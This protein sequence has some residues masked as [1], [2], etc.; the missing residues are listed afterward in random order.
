MTA[1]NTNKGYHII[2]RTD[3][4]NSEVEIEVSISVEL[5]QSHRGH[6]L[7]HINDRLEIDGFR[8][9]HVPESI[10]VAKIGEL[11]ILGEVAE[12]VINHIV[13]EI[14]ESEKIKMI[15]Y[16]NITFTKLAPGNPVEFKMRAA[17]MPEIEL[18]DYRKM[19]KDKNAEKDEVVKVSDKEV[20]D[21]IS[22]MQKRF[23]GAETDTREVV[24]DKPKLEFNDEFVRKLGNFKDLAD[25]KMK[26]K[27]N[28]TAD[29]KFKA[30]DKKRLVLAEAIVS[31][32]KTA[33]PEILV[34]HELHKME[35]Q[36]TDD[37]SR[38]GTKMEDYLKH[39]KKTID[40]LR[41][42]WRG[43]AEKRA[44]LQLVVNKIAS[45]EKITPTREEVTKE[46]K[47]LLEHHKDASKDRAEVYIE[48]VLTNEKVFEFLEKL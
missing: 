6:A 18:P 17:L 23:A 32:T 26:L 3:L 19:A 21:T 20:D 43:D 2:K 8:K 7:K 1:N 35:A 47:K 29:K 33:L 36:F 14:I 27:E 10:L 15:G 24:K 4:A 41:K 44:K 25:F 40:D 39:I 12:D 38:M 37:V 13:P 34:A 48:M 30:K 45:L 16:P 22:E 28:I 11:K 42:D 5:L 9:G 31:K 46:V